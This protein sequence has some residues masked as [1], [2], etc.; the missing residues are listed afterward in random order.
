MKTAAANTGRV[1]AASARNIAAAHHRAAPTRAFRSP[2][3]VAIR[4]AGT[5]VTRDPMPDSVMT[6]AA[7]AMSAPRSRA[8]SAMTGRIAPVATP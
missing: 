3:R 5:F 2:K 7:V 1:G 4:V 8:V 6:R